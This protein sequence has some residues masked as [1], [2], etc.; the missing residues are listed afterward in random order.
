M[1]FLLVPAHKAANMLTFIK[2]LNIL[3][4]EPSSAK[5]YEHSL[6]DLCHLSSVVD[7]HWYHIHIA[8]VWCVF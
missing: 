6:L 7:R 8:A 1:M 2:I 5:T 4:Q 3:K